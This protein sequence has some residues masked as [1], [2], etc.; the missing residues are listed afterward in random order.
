[1]PS[2][3]VYG[4]STCAPCN[5]LKYWLNKKNIPFTYINIDEDKKLEQ[6]AFSLAG[7]AIVPVVVVGDKVIAGFNPSLLQGA[8]I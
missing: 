4:R 5:T 1:M 3:K 2:I 7:Y 6:E 8:L